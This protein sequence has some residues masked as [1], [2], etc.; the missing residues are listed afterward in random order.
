MA[1]E[2]HHENLSRAGE[3]AIGSERN[4]GLTLGAAF[5]LLAILQW[6]RGGDRWPWMLVAAAAFVLAA[7]AW[8]P[9]L[10]PFN[11]AWFRLGLLLARTAQPVVLGLMF[12]VILAPFAMIFRRFARNPLGVGEGTDGASYWIARTPERPKDDLKNQF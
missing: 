11:R 3:V 2:D 8:P 7:A 9:I 10:R 5:T 1:I 6:Y 12:Y 4:F